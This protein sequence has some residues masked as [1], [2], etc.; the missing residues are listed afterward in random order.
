[1][2]RRSLKES[3]T[4]LQ[5]L[6]GVTDFRQ[7]A[8]MVEGVEDAI[9]DFVDTIDTKEEPSGSDT[10][11]SGLDYDEYLIAWTT[12][13]P[14]E[15]DILS[16]EEEIYQFAY[17]MIDNNIKPRPDMEEYMSGRIENDDLDVTVNQVF[18]KVWLLP[19]N[20]D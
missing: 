2:S 20:I 18:Y 7:P 11:V 10:I 15:M 5:A 16:S 17:Q 12:L 14:G 13:I 6:S 3:L 19:E 8:V 9:W 1:M 4:R